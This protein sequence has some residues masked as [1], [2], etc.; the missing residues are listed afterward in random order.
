VTT[1]QHQGPGPRDGGAVQAAAGTGAERVEALLAEMTPAEKV[2]QLVQTQVGVDR[3]SAELAE[4]IRGGRTGAVLNAVGAELTDTLQRIAV[5]ESR[6]GIPLL[7]GRDVIHGFRTVFPIPLGQAASWDPEGVRRAARIAALEAAAAGVNWTFA[8]TV[9]IGRDPRWGRVAEGLGE[10][11]HLASALAA[12][13]VR[14]FQ[15]ESPAAPGSIA[16]CAKHFAGYGAAE[17]GRDYAPA[18]IPEPELRDVHLPPFRAAIEAG[19]A[20]VMTAFHDLNGVPATANAFLLQTVLREEWGFDGLVVSDWRAVPELI[21]HGVARDVA[22]AA[23]LAAEAGVDMDM[24]GDAFGPHLEPLVRGGRVCAQRLDGM[25]RSVLRLKE[26]LGLFDHPYTEPS[27]FPVPGCADHL[28]AARDAA[29]RSVVLLKNDGVLPLDPALSRVA[30]LGPLADDGYEQLGTWIFDGDPGLSRTP[31]AA[32]R[33]AL[34]PEVVID[35]VRALE[36]TRSR[37]TAGIAGAVEA[38]AAADVA[39]LFVGEESILSGE[40]HSRADIRLPGAQ[41]ELIRAVAGA[42]TPVVA[43]LLSGRPLALAGVVDAV[44]ALLCAWHPGTMG[45]PAIVDLLLGRATPSGKLPASFPRM[46]GQVPLY[47][48]RKNTGRPFGPGPATPLDAIPPRAPQHSAGNGSFHLDA[49]ADPLFAFGHGLSYTRFEYH[50][51]R[52]EPAVITPDGAVT[53]TADVRNAGDRPGEEVVQLYVRD[54][55]AS[56]T[57][58]VRELKGFRRVALDPGERRTVSF[59]LAARDLAFHGPDGPRLEPGE[60]QVWIGGSSTADLGAGFALD[61]G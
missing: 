44:D 30:V 2:G 18:S 40:A 7:V 8:P 48:A 9:D 15:G 5:E 31:L 25:V 12:A 11:P 57:R 60:F 16:A 14:G 49:G 20:T 54:R 21:D 41:E 39:L 58:P 46:S 53:V 38:A 19:V 43:V 61:P 1:E 22:D 10:D 42:G 56:L 37:D 4:A 29:T 6:L 13:M 17:A 36:T 3:V 33:A 26:R 27:R 50:R 23:A 45:G 59:T 51:I 32:L 52:A 55:V 35:P 24:A 47:Y 28:A 34:E